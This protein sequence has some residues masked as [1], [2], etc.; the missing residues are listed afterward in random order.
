M[1]S[2]SSHSRHMKMMNLQ[3]FTYQLTI[4]TKNLYVE[5]KQ[6][7]LCDIK[8]LFRDFTKGS[9]ILSLT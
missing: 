9:K 2:D 7:G 5:P 6:F 8:N 1:K 4:L 3:V